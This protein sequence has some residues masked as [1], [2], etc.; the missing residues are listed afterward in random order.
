[1][2]GLRRFFSP[3]GI[4][5]DWIQLCLQ[6]FW[7]ELVCQ[8]G[9]RE[10]VSRLLCLVPSLLFKSWKL[11]L[12]THGTSLKFEYLIWQILASFSLAVIVQSQHKTLVPLFQSPSFSVLCFQK[13]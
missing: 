6:A 4:F 2:L 10:G 8:R 9:H 11:V 1:M 3:H 5:H 12:G 7:A 13:C